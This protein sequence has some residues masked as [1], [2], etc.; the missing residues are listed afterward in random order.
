[1]KTLNAITTIN[2][3][4][5]VLR[6]DSELAAALNLAL[7]ALREQLQAE[8][9]Q[10]RRQ[11]PEQEQAPREASLYPLTIVADRYGGCY[12]GGAYTAWQMEPWE[13]PSDISDGDLDCSI[14][15]AD[16][17][18]ICGKGSTPDEAERDLLKKIRDGAG[19]FES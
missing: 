14:F 4:L 17:E 10:Q 16:N 6:A 18:L 3:T 7:S 15:W 8:L 13:V 1:M 19:L 9:K 5:A 11:P 12:S 2:E